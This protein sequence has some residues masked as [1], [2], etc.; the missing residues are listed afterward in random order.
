MC[1]QTNTQ[2]YVYICVDIN[3]IGTKIIGRNRDFKYRFVY[4][5]CVCA[6]M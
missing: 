1:A 2:I 3:D 6:W 4:I 5:V